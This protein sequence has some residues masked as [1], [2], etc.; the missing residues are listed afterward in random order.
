MGGGRPCSPSAAWGRCTRLDSPAPTGSDACSCPPGA[1][2]P[3]ITKITDASFDADVLK[4][5]GPV[6]VDF[7]A[8]WCGPCKQIAPA[9]EDL[10]TEFGEK[11]TVA[12]LNIDE[13]PKIPGQFGVR[14]IP[15]LML[16]KDGQMTSMKVGAM[17]KAR[18][19]EWLNEAGVERSAAIVA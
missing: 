3:V 12:K 18:I 2:D 17:P 11:V 15:T 14:G 10:A 19:L 8:E 5:T 16:F 4:A 9:L 7:W 1:T 6:L 13:N